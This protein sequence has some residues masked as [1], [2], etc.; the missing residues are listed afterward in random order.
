MFNFLS[1][2]FSGVL[3]WL[4]DKGRLTDDNIRDATNQVRT[5]LLE[6][7]VPNNVV[8]DFL[9]QVQQEMVGRKIHESLNPG[10]QLIKVVHDKVLEFLGGKNT[11]PSISFQIPSV[12]MVMGLQGSGKTTTI[13]K[14]AYYIQDQAKKRGKARRILLGSVD[15]YRPAAIDQLEIL[16]KQVGV[17]FFRATSTDPVKAA[18]EINEHFKQNSYE[19]LLLDTAGRLH[20]DETMMEELKI[21]TAKVAPKY[22]FLILDAMTGQESLTVAKA[23][24]S[25][26]GFDYAALSKMDSDTRGGAAFGFRYELKK[27]IVFVG[28]GEKPEDLEAFIPERMTTRILGMGDIM[29]LIE[30]ATD[31]I[32][33]QEQSSMTQKLMG[34]HFSLKDFADQMGML[35][36]LG[37]LQ[38]ISR[39]LPGMGNLSPEVMEKGQTEMKRFRAIISSMTN[40]E[41]LVPSII[42]SSRRK[43][44]AAG[45][46]STVQDVNQLL[47][48]FE[49]SKEMLKMFKK[50]GMMRKFFK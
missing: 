25:A 49:Q 42:D 34:G 14:L 32:S 30:K 17:N 5:A 26:I 2:K 7:D 48:R 10:Q 31:Q 39:Y 36:R 40:K 37:S 21:I 47:Q 1:E 33:E 22:K 45:S 43:R 18:V 46:G 35:D 6:A 50:S 11:V 16:A 41:K 4:K 20:I 3:G 28:I 38:K 9:T 24:D 27:P 23:F 8:E 44:I 12:V 19:H 15:F 13:A 29:T